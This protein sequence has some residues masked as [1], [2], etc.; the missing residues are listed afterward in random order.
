MA[1]RRWGEPP[2]GQAARSA[3]APVPTGYAPLV[4]AAPRIDGRLDDACWAGAPA[5]KLARTLDGNGR[6][7]QPAEARAVRHAG[8]LYVA[9]R[10]AEP[11]VDKIRAARRSHDGEIW[12]DDSVEMFL[13]VGG[14]Y[15]H[16]GISAASATYDGKAKNSS[17]NSGF[18]AAA[19]KGKGEWTAEVAIPLKSMI[20]KGKAPPAWIANFT[21]N[22]HVTGGWQ[23]SAWSPTLSGDSHVPGRFGKLLFARPPAGPDRLKPVVRQEVTILP[24]AEGAGVGVVRFDLSALPRRARVYRADLLVF[25][26]QPVDGRDDEAL[27]DIEIYPLF[28]DFKAGGRPKVSGQPLALRPAWFDRFD[29]TDAVRRCVRGKTNPPRA[30]FFIKAGAFIDAAA[31]CLDVAYEGKPP[32]VPRQVSGVKTLHRAGQTFIT[33]KEIDD[34]VGGDEINWV[35]LRRILADLDKQRRLRYCVYRSDRRITSGNLHQA[36]LIASVAPLSC[37]NVNGRNVDK[38]ID[39]ALGNQYFLR[40]H[41][42]NPFVRASVEGKYGVDCMMERLVIRD[43]DKPL[44]RGTGLYVHTPRGKS[45][46]YYAVVT[47]LDGVQNTIDISEEN[48]PPSPVQESEGVGEPVLQ[49]AF[50]PKPYFNYREK[51]LHYVRWVAP[52]YCNL[53]SQYYNWSVGVPDR[54]GQ[55]M[56]VEL[57]LHRDGRSYHRSQYRV[58]QDSLLLAPHDFPIKT[59]WHGYHESLGMLRSF[60]R[61]RVHNYT[62]RRL[63]AFIDWAAG[64]WPI[65][66]SRILVTGCA[67][68]GAG[69]GALHLGI[70]H[71]EVFN[72]VLSGYGLANYAGEIDALIRVKRAGSMPA[73]MES[74]WG[75][76]EWRLKTD[77]G[78]NVW[79]ELNLTRTVADLPDKTDLPLVSVTGRGMLKPMRDF[80]VAMLEQGQPVM[81]RYGVYGGGTLLPVGRTGTWSRMIRQDLSRSQSMPAFWGPGA[82][83]LWETAREPSGNL[84]V[85][86]G[87]RRWWG[88]IGTGFRWK[89]DDLVD[90][91]SRYEITLFWAGS[92]RVRKPHATVTLRRIQ[93]F[94][95]RPDWQYR[96]ELRNPAGEVVEQGKVAPGKRGLFVFKGVHIPRE[97]V[98]LIVRP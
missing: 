36:E 23:E 51:R 61:G 65:D 83:S 98:R 68:G 39:H 6:A 15:Y 34:P 84:V 56:P 88:E 38:P 41:Q 31:A 43:G 71:P 29:A 52:P 3:R 17:W 33:W 87:I 44:P 21:R 90:T 42:W 11:D 2:A 47:S 4:E 20:G 79:D 30:D 66:R 86:D 69:G 95:I 18:K 46:A 74:I 53:P 80:F 63:L 35:R 85:S 13:G 49:K 24:V 73:E 89:T 75:K 12:S 9:F 55:T 72:L 76:L 40:H 77:A 97:G 59:W 37:W 7:A 16:F 96:Y 8:T 92:S 10:C 50:P 19:E 62:E 45:E 14:T 67:G 26:T 93:K 54:H 48:S 28:S 25:R 78:R 1:T 81:C 32:D 27:I 94:R 58:E 70:R 5:M 64:K 91:P 22:R 57:S 60:R 82:S